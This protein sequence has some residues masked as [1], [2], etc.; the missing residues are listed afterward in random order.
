MGRIRKSRCAAQQSALASEAVVKYL[1]V[2]PRYL[3][4]GVVIVETDSLFDPIVP[5]ADIILHNDRCGSGLAAE[6]CYPSVQHFLESEPDS[7]SQ[8]E[9]RSGQKQT[10]EIAVFA[11]CQLDQSESVFRITKKA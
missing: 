2:K 1:L 4:D 3:V 10:L 6:G 9:P 11:G 7:A 5:E 8:Q